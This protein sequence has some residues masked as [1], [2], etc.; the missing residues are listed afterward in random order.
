MN[1]PFMQDQRKTIDAIDVK[2]LELL[3]KRMRCS[4]AIGHYKKQQNLPIVQGQRWQE[5]LAA[6]IA[7]GKEEGLSEAYIGTIL[8]TIHDES[9][10]V[11]KQIVEG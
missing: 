1:S 3:G 11:Q 9:V 2:I 7:Q 8:H 5:L 6:R 10:R 4:H